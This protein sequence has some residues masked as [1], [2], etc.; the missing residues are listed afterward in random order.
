MF[1]KQTEIKDLSSI[2]ERS[3]VITENKKSEFLNIIPVL[4]RN[5]MQ[6]VMDFFLLA[7]KK[8]KKIVD[9]YGSKKQSFYEICLSKLNRAYVEARKIVFKTKEKKSSKGDD[10]N[11]ESLINELNII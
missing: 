4:T 2:I 10:E 1:A 5:Q 8:I 6:D 7:E 9:E 11:I 3:Q